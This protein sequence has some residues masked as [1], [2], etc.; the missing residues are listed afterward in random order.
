MIELSMP[1]SAPARLTPPLLRETPGW[2][3]MN[4]PEGRDGKEEGGVAWTDRPTLFTIFTNM[5]L[6]LEAQKL[7]VEFFIIEH[8]EPRAAN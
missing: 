3:P 7:P 1:A 6:K 2:A 8:A 4:P 5:G